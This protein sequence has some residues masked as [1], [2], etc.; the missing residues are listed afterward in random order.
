MAQIEIVDAFPHF[1][2][3]W[4]DARRLP[5]EAL[6]ESWARE[7]MAAWPELLAKQL[8]DYGSQ[9]E[10]WQAVALERVFPFLNER[11]PAMQTAHRNLLEACRPLYVALTL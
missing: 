7:Q 10:D 4:L 9:G 5:L 8:N 1:L 6:V 2:S 3:F 11:L